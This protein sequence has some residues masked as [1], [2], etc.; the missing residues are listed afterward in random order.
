MTPTMP[1]SVLLDPEL[2]TPAVWLDHRVNSAR[3][4]GSVAWMGHDL[5]TGRFIE[6]QL[7]ASLE[8]TVMAK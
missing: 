6:I 4:S 1:R 3:G 7:R 5:D 2:G 8:V